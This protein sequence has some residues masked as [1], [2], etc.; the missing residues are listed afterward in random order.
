MSLKVFHIVFISISI[1]LG[2]FFAVWCLMEYAAEN[3]SFYLI[4]FVLTLLMTFG[5]VI[6]GRWFLKK[7]KGIQL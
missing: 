1:L 2:I 4:M 7:V 3:D 5:L 6:Y